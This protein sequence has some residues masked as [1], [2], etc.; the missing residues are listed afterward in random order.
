M[1]ER[2]SEKKKKRLG[3]EVGFPDV[4]EAL[5]LLAFA[6]L[7]FL[8]EFKLLLKRTASLE[9]E[10][11][12]LRRRLDELESWRVK[13]E[14]SKGATATAKIGEQTLEQPPVAGAS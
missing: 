4:G 10:N 9:V 13:V 6:S 11:K 1:E 14:L 12:D 3:V 5:G 7:K 2:N 8:D